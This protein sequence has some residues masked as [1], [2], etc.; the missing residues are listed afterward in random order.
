MQVVRDDE[1]SL[2]HQKF[3]LTDDTLGQ[4]YKIMCKME[5]DISLYMVHKV[6][7]IIFT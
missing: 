3:R 1:L 7:A 6:I 2:S 4:A 5:N